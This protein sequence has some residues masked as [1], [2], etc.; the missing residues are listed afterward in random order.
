MSAKRYSLRDKKKVDLPDDKYEQALSKIN[1][2]ETTLREYMKEN[3]TLKR[4]I[5]R[6]NI[7]IEGKKDLKKEITQLKNSVKK[8]E[9]K[10]E[11]TQNKL[12]AVRE[13]RDKLKKETA[14][15]QKK[16]EKLEYNPIR[17]LEGM[18]TELQKILEDSKIDHKKEIL[19]IDSLKKAH[20]YCKILKMSGQ[21]TGPLLEHYIKHK[22]NMTKNDASDCIGDLHCNKKNY[23]IKASLGGQDNN[24]FNFVQLR[25]DHKCSYIFT[26]YYIDK[27]NLKHN[28]KLYIFQLEKEDIKEL[29][30]KYGTYAHG[31]NGS[32][33]NITREE[34]DRRINTKE[35]ALRPKY[36]D[37]CWK[38]LLRFEV[39]EITV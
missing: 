19:K 5:E 23:E 11:K 24:K 21:K 9:N 25:M 10:N 27:F 4:D 7:E 17:V 16:I 22:N 1:A 35:Y 33:G 8:L 12:I 20:I 15:L 3:A 13:E 38:D 31:T 37:K 6:A 32:L 36:D 29:L 34:L 14:K 18:Q 2:L 26:A 39:D 30:I 28:G